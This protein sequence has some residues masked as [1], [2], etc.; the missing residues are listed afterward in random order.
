MLRSQHAGGRPAILCRRNP[1]DRLQYLL[2]LLLLPRC[3][4]K[5]CRGPLG[6]YLTLLSGQADAPSPPPPLPL[7]SAFPL[8]APQPTVQAAAADPP[9]L[10]TG[11]CIGTAMRRCQATSSLDSTSIIFGAAPG[12]LSEPGAGVRACP[13]RVLP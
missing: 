2:L 11:N 13:I 12:G 8:T 7:C 3:R 6:R 5:S 10:M 4:C 1:I 9:I